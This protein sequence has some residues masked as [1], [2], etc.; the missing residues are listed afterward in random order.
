MFIR[1]FFDHSIKGSDD[2]FFPIAFDLTSRSVWFLPKLI[3]YIEY[4]IIFKCIEPTFLNIYYFGYLGIN[5]CTILTLYIILLFSSRGSIVNDKPRKYMAIFV[6][7]K[8]FFEL[9]ESLWIVFGILWLARTQWNYCSLFLCFSIIIDIL[10]S[11]FHLS[12]TITI[13]LLFYD[14]LYGAR[15]DDTETRINK[16]QENIKCLFKFVFYFL[17]IKKSKLDNY[18]YAY[19]QMAKILEVETI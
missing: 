2:F 7:L 18:N 12:S 9:I 10:L 5:A 15:D 4:Q 11:L 17:F 3:Y 1:V 6:Y 14:P 8:L 16:L 13:L 19:R